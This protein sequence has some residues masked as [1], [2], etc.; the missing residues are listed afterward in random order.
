M[1]V[2]KVYH[3]HIIYTAL[4]GLCA[5]TWGMHNYQPILVR[6]G[7]GHYLTTGG[8]WW[9]SVRA[10]QRTGPPPRGSEEFWSPPREGSTFFRSPPLNYSNARAFS[11]KRGDKKLVP[12][13]WGSEEFWSPPLRGS[14]E[15]WSP[16]QIHQPPPVVK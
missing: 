12:P 11:L 1:S 13:L 7:S 3:R 2:F 9:I 10:R 8:G 16:P 5:F 4:D 15:F 6:L 14:E